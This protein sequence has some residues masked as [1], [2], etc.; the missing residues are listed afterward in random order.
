VS[1]QVPSRAEQVY[2]ILYPFT[3]ILLS[4]IR[5]QADKFWNP[6]VGGQVFESGIWNY[7]IHY[8]LFSLLLPFRKINGKSCKF[9]E[10]LTL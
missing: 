8:P 9:E 4:G 6:P 2:F 1:G 3:F 10:N 7:L 5:Q